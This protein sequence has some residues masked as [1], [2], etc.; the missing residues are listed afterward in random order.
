MI[1]SVVYFSLHFFRF[2]NTARL[3][4]GAGLHDHY[5]QG[6]FLQIFML[7]AQVHQ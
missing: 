3:L 5:H 4:D 6:H 2:R 1:R 7:S